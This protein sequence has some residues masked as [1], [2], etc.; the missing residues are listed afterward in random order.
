MGYTLLKN[1]A[2]KQIAI[3][4]N[5]SEK[6]EAAIRGMDEAVWNEKAQMWILPE[7]CLDQVEFYRDKYVPSSKKKESAA[8]PAK[9]IPIKAEEQPKPEPEPVPEPIKEPDPEQV[10]EADPEPKSSETPESEPAPASEPVTEQKQ[11]TKQKRTSNKKEPEAEKPFQSY[12]ITAPIIPWRDKLGELY[13]KAKKDGNQE[14]MDLLVA[15]GNMAKND[16]NLQAAIE[17]PQKTFDR[18]YKFV[19]DKVMEKYLPKE[20]RTGQQCVCVSNNAVLKM[21]L[22]YIWDDDYQKIVDEEKAEYDRKIKEAK[23]KE[24]AEKEKKKKEKQKQAVAP[25]PVEIPAPKPDEKPE[26]APEDT[27]VIPEP[28]PSPVSVPEPEPETETEADEVFDDQM[29]LL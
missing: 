5:G 7:S 24:K 11:E 9:I 20:K 14:F 1:P 26:E 17:Q 4:G 19:R 23:Q 18:G 22:E 8:E 29:S 28:E 16:I 2:T 12:L 6:F 13:R 25:A 10:K 3:R 21:V 15:L 27:P